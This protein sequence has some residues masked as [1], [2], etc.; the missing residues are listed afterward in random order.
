MD[1]EVCA[2]CEHDLSRHYNDVEN[3]VR[4]LYV[5]RG[6]STS[7]II[8]LPYEVHCDCKNY[9]SARRES[10][11]RQQREDDERFK[12]SMLRHFGGV[13]GDAL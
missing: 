6:T 4:C 10:A 2:G 3:T 12:T 5:E 11:E 13:K 7:G 1:D 8:G 9:R